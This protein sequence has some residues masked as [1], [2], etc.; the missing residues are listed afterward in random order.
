MKVLQFTVLFTALHNIFRLLKIKGL[1]VKK[2]NTEI[3]FHITNDK[4]VLFQAAA[5]FAHA[6]V[7]AL[8]SNTLAY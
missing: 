7:S 1:D 5:W 6:V 4:N 8:I 3:N 2:R